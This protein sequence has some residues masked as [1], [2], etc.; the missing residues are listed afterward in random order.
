MSYVT[1]HTSLQFDVCR[2]M[3]VGDIVVSSMRAVEIGV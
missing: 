1:R 2:M 3:N